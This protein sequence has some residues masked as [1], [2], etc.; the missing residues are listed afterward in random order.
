MNNLLYS[1]EKAENDSVPLQF[2]TRIQ[3]PDNNP[4]K[5]EN[6]YIYN[7]EE[8]IPAS[9]S[10][11]NKM[12]VFYDSLKVLASKHLITS[13]LYDLI[14]V[15]GQPQPIKQMRESSDLNYSMHTGKKIRN[16]DIRRLN[17]FGTS[18]ENP[19]SSDPTKIENLL[20]KTHLNTN[21]FIIRNN[22]LFS[23]GDTVSPLI[24]SDNERVLRQL[25]YIDDSRIIITPVSEEEVD[26]LVYTK[27]VYSIGG[28]FEYKTLEKGSLSIFEKNVL[29]LGHEFRLELPYDPDLPD[30]PGFGLKYNINNIARLFINMDL[31][32]F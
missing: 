20:N 19:L 6:S 11:S 24:L 28:T 5:S 18:I 30:S 14:I 3:L 8:L 2:P 22:L 15:S 10:L 9:A 25:P 29:G 7:P 13:K 31:F 16:I 26:I 23:E 4:F 17:I 12:P 32:Y 1:Q 21:E 27:D